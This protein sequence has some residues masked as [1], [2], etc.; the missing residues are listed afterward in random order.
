MSDDDICCMIW[1][2]LVSSLVTKWVYLQ[3][4]TN[5]GLGYP[6]NPL[7]SRPEAYIKMEIYETTHIQI[8]LR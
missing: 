8:Q 2:V 5:K 6:H 7:A 3:Q 1:Q 4:G